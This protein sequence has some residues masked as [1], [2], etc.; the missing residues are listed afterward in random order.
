MAIAFAGRHF[1]FYWV[2]R[3]TPGG[4]LGLAVSRKVSNAVVRN[5]V[6]RYL[7][8]FYRTHRPTLLKEAYLVMV[9]RPSA[10]QLN[11]TECAEEYGKLLKRGGLM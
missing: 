5:R 7:R 3:D 11:Y 9:A 8:E 1:I 2:E 10:A 6:K 4:K